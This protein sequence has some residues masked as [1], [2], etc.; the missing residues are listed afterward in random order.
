MVRTRDFIILILIV[1]FLL[2]A[3]I[4][5]SM[6]PSGKTAD[7]L[8][9][10]SIEEYGLIENNNHDTGPDRDANIDRLRSKIAAGTYLESVNPSVESGTE[11]VNDDNKDEELVDEEA[12]VLKRCARYDDGLSVA[13][14]WPRE[15]ISLNESGAYRSW[16]VLG[17]D[18]SEITILRLP[19]QPFFT[20]GTNCL[21]SEVIGVSVNGSLLFNSDAI[22]YANSSGDRLIGYALDG[23]PIYGH[24]DLVPVDQCG[25]FEHATGYRYQIDPDRPFILGCYRSVSQDLLPYG[26]FDI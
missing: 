26:N 10:T 19:K 1:A 24:T 2:M 11:I 13:M 7:V 18:G 5:A 4:H 8:L 15:S 6:R 21:D 12:V 25:G 22:V 16:S 17:S 20:S 3:I 14:V 9:A 23:H